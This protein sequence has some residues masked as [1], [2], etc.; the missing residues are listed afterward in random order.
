MATIYFRGFDFECEY[1]YSPEEK[2]TYDYPGYPETWEFFNITLN[3]IDASELL[4]HCFEDFEEQAIKQ[5]TE[6]HG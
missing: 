4:E 6:Y 1:D 3:G 5:L 2:R